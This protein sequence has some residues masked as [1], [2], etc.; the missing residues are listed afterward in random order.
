[1]GMLQ[2][3]GDASGR[4]AWVAG[5]GGPEG[6]DVFHG[7][8]SLAAITETGNVKAQHWRDSSIKRMDAVAPL[9]HDLAM[10]E[11]FADAADRLREIDDRLSKDARLKALYDDLQKRYM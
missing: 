6:T 5:A 2:P 9:H 8:D 1:M 4:L 11:A 3:P 10:Q 7:V